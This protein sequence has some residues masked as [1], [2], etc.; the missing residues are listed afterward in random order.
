[1]NTNRNFED[2]MKEL[3]Q[4]KNESIM[5]EYEKMT[6]KNESIYPNSIDEKILKAVMEYEKEEKAKKKKK[7]FS[8]LSKVAVFLIVCAVAVNYVFPEHVEAFKIKVMDVFFD[9]EA[10]AVNIKG[11]GEEALLEGWTE[12]Y[13]P[14]YMLEKYSLAGAEKMGERCVML[15]LSDD[16]EH[17]IKI[18][19]LPA[20]STVNINTDDAS[21]EDVKVGYYK[22]IYV[23]DTENENAIITWMNDTNIF[24]VQGDT[25]VT[26]DEYIKIAASLKYIDR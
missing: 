23:V 10:G 17:Q 21:V 1:M 12:Y 25:S 24:N 3:L 14:G 18:E 22:G 19:S 8:V 2:I 7:L 20:N 4:E 6:E 13:Y 5:N 9:D 15:F 26:K 16:G 11:E